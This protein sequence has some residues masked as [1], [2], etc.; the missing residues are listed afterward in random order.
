MLA[1]HHGFFVGAAEHG[2]A[3]ARRLLTAFKPCIIWTLRAA[4]STT[5]LLCPQKGIISGLLHRTGPNRELDWTRFRCSFSSQWMQT[6]VE[7]CSSRCYWA[8]AK[9]GSLSSHVRRALQTPRTTPLGAQV[10]GRT[11]VGPRTQGD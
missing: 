4:I 9:T 2:A 7:Y 8:E 10:C 5:T 11:D 3:S 1:W 6:G